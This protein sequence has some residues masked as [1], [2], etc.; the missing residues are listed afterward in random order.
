MHSI[1]I[2][3]EGNIDTHGEPASITAQTICSRVTFKD[4]FGKFL[5]SVERMGF[6]FVTSEVYDRFM[7]AFDKDIE[8]NGEEERNYWRELYTLSK[9]DEDNSISLKISIKDESE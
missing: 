3:A 6:N 8:L 7:E 5:Y 4:V 2:E 9:E 1:K